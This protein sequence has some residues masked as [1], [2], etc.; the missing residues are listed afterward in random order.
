M[1]KFGIPAIVIFPHAS[2]SVSELA[3]SSSR[4]ALPTCQSRGTSMQPRVQQPWSAVAQTQ[5]PR[6][7]HPHVASLTGWQASAAGILVML[8]L[9]HGDPAQ[10]R[11]AQQALLTPMSAAS[12][13]TELP[14]SPSRYASQSVWCALKGLMFSSHAALTRSQYLHPSARCPNQEQLAMQGCRHALCTA[15][16]AEI[17]SGQSP[18]APACPSAGAQ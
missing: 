11:L 6:R 5:A 8:H 18:S 4:S 7:S 16:A 17:C 1:Q 14:D 13:W 3:P 9:M 12:A 2:R 10:E 15:C